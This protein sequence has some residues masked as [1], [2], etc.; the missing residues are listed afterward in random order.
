[1]IKVD[2]G[3]EC[4]SK[5]MERYKNDASMLTYLFPR[6]TPSTRSRLGAVTTRSD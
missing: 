2:K 3:S 5:A 6:G 1:M 4:I